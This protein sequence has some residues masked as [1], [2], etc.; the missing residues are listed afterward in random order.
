MRPQHLTDH[1]RHRDL[2]SDSTLHVV[3][4]VTNPIRYQTRYRLARQFI[5]EMEATR[6]VRL[7]VAEAAFGDRHHEVTEPCEPGGEGH[8]TRHLRVRTR[9]HIWIKENLMN[10]AVRL[11]PRDWK[12]VAFVDADVSFRNPDWAME[13]LH[14]LQYHPVIQ[15]WRQAHDLGPRGEVMKTF[16]SFGYCW[17]EGRPH[18]SGEPQH[19]ASFGH[20]GYAHA[21]TR[22][23]YE[24]VGGLPDFAIL[25]SGDRHMLFGCIGEGAK[26]VAFG[27]KKGVSGRIHRGY[28]DRVEEWGRKAH[29]ASGGN[30]GYVE[31]RL[32][33]HYHGSKQARQY[34]DRW[35]I[36]ADH[37]YDPSADLTYDDQGLIQ[38]TGKPALE[39]AIHRYCVGRDEDGI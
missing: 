24:A 10:L 12:Y 6:D 31:G 18:P 37:G 25:G 22:R 8:H 28:V 23:F 39:H 33:H 14:A 17:Q 13:T 11:L 5:A 3:T 35:G 1:H 20:P 2:R 19:Y 38:L 16:E 32:E 29:R 7:Y 4:C 9:S 30:V 15:P 26:S 34:S 21:M 27:A 36:L